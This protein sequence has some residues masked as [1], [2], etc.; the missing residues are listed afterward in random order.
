M[1]LLVDSV[2]TTKTQT[3]TDQLPDIP[4]LKEPKED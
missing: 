1:E 3:E 4:I 2:D